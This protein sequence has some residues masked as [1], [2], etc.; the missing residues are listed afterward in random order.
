MEYVSF[1]KLRGDDHVIAM[2]LAHMADLQVEWSDRSLESGDRE[3]AHEHA[4][5]ATFPQATL[6]GWV[7][8][9]TWRRRRWK[10]RLGV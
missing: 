2:G 1:E 4:L 10:R 8:T 7:N 5:I 3:L 6:R 9:S